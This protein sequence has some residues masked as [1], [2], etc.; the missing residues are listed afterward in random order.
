MLPFLILM[1]RTVIPNL[2][3]SYLCSEWGLSSYHFFFEDAKDWASHFSEYEELEGEVKTSKQ[4]GHTH[5]HDRPHQIT[6]PGEVVLP[7]TDRNDK[8]PH[9]SEPLAMNGEAGRLRASRRI[10][11]V[12]KCLQRRPHL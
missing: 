7:T 3:F 11:A 4:E 6:Q 9:L 1:L 8:N 12:G 10:I 2:C 5:T